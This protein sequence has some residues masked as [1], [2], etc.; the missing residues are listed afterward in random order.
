M[1]FLALGLYMFRVCYCR[2]MPS[3]ER[4]EGFSSSVKDLRFSDLADWISSQ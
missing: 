4:D 3:L 2:Y 1:F